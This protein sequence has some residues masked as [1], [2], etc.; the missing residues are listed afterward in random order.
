MTATFAVTA[1]LAAGP[2]IAEYPERE[3]TMIVNAGAG[4][5]TSAG[6]RILA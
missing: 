6:A 1:M 3:I 2:A 4:G 5:S